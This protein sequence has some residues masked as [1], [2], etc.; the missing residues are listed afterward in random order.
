MQNPMSLIPTTRLKL[1]WNRLVQAKLRPDSIFCFVHIPKNAGT[2]VRAYVV[3]NN[4]YSRTYILNPRELHL[5]EQL[6][7]EEKAKIGVVIGHYPYAYRLQNHLPRKCSFATVLR[8]PKA[9]VLSLYSYIASEPEHRL[10]SAV[11]GGQ[12]TLE[13]F[14]KRRTSMHTENGQVRFL[15]DIDLDVWG[16]KPCTREMLEQAKENLERDFEFIGFAE[17]MDSFYNDVNKSFKWSS[18][19]VSKVNI[20]KKRIQ[21]NEISETALQLINDYNQLD[22]ELYEFAQNLKKREKPICLTTN[23]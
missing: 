21:E 11:I 19:H 2:S 20:T 7:A 8:H 16:N 17:D 4:L 15:C 18:R 1:I 6:S 14:I 9:R 3:G 10:H 23:R 5:L 13:D 12:L 22:L